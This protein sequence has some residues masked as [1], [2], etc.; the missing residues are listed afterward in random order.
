MNFKDLLWFFSFFVVVVVFFFIFK[1]V[2]GLLE[3]MT[4]LVYLQQRCGK[5]WDKS[6]K[7]DI[8]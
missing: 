5:Q 6:K 8:D 7:R 1:G 2:K 3:K 4:A